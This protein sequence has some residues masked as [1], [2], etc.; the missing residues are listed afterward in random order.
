MATAVKGPVDGGDGFGE[1]RAAAMG[2]SGQK[3][4]SSS[5]GGRRKGL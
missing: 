5:S 4:H 2:K 1:E 3:P